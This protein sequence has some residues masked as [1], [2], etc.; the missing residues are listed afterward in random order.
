MHCI[1]LLS[2]SKVCHKIKQMNKS[3]TLRM[4][5]PFIAN[6]YNTIQQRYRPHTRAV[7][8]ASGRS[9]ILKEANT[10]CCASLRCHRGTVYTH[11]TICHRTCTV[12]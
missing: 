1:R 8:G 3:D 11:I 4:K 2:L 5:T 12:R 9:Y 6:K 10:L 7:C